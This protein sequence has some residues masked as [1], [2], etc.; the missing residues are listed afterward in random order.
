MQHTQDAY[1]RYAADPYGC[2]SGDLYLHI[3]SHCP[4]YGAGD[5][6]R[7]GNTYLYRNI[8]RYLNTNSYRNSARGYHDSHIYQ[9]INHGSYIYIYS[10]TECNTG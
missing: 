5:N 8:D 7:Y 10:F 1:V 4:A 9:Y 3:Y 6:V 2:K